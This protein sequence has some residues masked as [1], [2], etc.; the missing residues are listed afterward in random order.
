MGSGIGECLMTDE[1]A[2]TGYRAAG[3]PRDPRIERAALS[4]VRELLV[5]QG[6]AAVTVAAVAERAGTTKA[7]LY[8]RWPA[9]AHLV[10]E[11]VFPDELAIDLTL[12]ADL[13]TDLVGIVHGTR[14]A[15]C[16]PVAAAALPGLLSEFSAHPQ[17]HADMLGRFSGVFGALE[18]RLRRAAEDGEVRADARADDVLGLVV[19][20]VLLGLLVARDQLDD[21][22]ADRLATTLERGIRP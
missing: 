15:F 13:H 6:Y 8:R 4:A 10:H 14:E 11:A 22:W 2:Q 12:G 19:G 3:R 20:A 21:A 5:E 18:T 16:T 9:L 1:I 17:L 7:A